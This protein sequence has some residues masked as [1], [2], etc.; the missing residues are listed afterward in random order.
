[1]NL[2]LC[3]LKLAT[4]AITAKDVERCLRK[5][6]SSGYQSIAKERRG[7]VEYNACENCGQCICISCIK[8]DDCRCS[9]FCED[10]PL[11]ECNDKE[12]DGFNT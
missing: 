3:L 4:I 12:F 1:M 2:Q 10:N 5:V 7:I 11:T 8:R 9:M 6:D